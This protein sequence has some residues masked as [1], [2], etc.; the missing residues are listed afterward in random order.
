[1]MAEGP[2]GGG[3]LGGGLEERELAGEVTGDWTLR[4]L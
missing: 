4:C 3:R 1:M 2:R